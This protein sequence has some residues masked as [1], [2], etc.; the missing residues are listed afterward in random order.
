M[1]EWFYHD[2]AEGRVGPFAAEDIRER[3]RQRRIMMDTPLWR[4]GMGK[5][6][7]LSWL[8]DELGL[9]DVPQD[10]RLPPPLPAAP[11]AAPLQTPTTSRKPARD[12]GEDRASR[13][14]WWVIGL[15]LAASLIGLLAMNIY[16]RFHA[17]GVREKLNIAIDEAAP[18]RRE[19]EYIMLNQYGCPRSG[20][21]MKSRRAYATP[22]L[23]SIDARSSYPVCT[24][25]LTIRDLDPQLDGRKLTLAATWASRD[26]LIWGCRE[27]DIE[28]R[29]LSALCEDGGLTDP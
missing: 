21:G 18:A 13:G 15:G 28:E 3:Y 20:F 17:A 11:G 6:Q 16:S 8:Q 12:T 24:L 25:T 2:P 10:D 22:H 23:V 7:P 26:T 29:Y 19:L 4:E 9:R 5:W 1:H 27:S 14:M